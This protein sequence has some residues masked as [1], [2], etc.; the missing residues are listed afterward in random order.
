MEYGNL[1]N[2]VL[3]EDHDLRI[4]AEK[5]RSRE[6]QEPLWNTEVSSTAKLVRD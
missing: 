5:K 2:N 1:I 3:S 4:G 6:E